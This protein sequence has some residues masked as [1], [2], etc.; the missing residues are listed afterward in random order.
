MAR[1]PLCGDDTETKEQ[2]NNQAQR[3]AVPD[4]D[5]VAACGN[6]LQE[7]SDDH[8]AHAEGD[9]CCEQR[10]PGSVGSRRACALVELVEATAE[11]CGDGQKE[12]IPCGGLA[13]V[14]HQES[15][16]DGS[17]RA[18]D[19][20]NERQRLGE[21]VQ[22]AVPIGETVE[23]ESLASNSVCDGQNDAEHHQHGGDKP[24]AAERAFNL[25]LEEQTQDDDG[26]TAE[27]DQPTHPCIRIV[28][29]DL[30]GE[31]T[32]PCPDDPEDVAPEVDD[33]GGF[34]SKLGDGGEGRSGVLRPG[35]QFPDD[36]QV[37]T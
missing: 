18:G 1:R 20:G 7:P 9:K 11:D 31:R 22:D 27:N 32:E 12:G 35:Q 29:W 3:Y 21:A 17:A 26:N 5:S 16:G 23:G 33:D 13:G 15:R 34:S 4:E 6:E 14:A 28:S 10:L 37:C 8:V 30:P 2:E 19:A 25:V 24:H 36:P